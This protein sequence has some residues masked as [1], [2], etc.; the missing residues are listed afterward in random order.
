MLETLKE[1][2]N[3]Y[4]DGAMPELTLDSS[5][6]ADLGLC[7]ME[8]YELLSAIEERFD[9]EIPDRVLSKLITVRD[10]VAYLEGKVK[11]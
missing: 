10:V 4:L 11:A 2:V 7:S 3:G 8:L 9:I 6:S 1:I 5:L